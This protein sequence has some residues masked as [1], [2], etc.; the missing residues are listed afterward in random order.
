LAATLL[1]P[2][3]N[4]PVSIGPVTGRGKVVDINAVSAINIP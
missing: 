3:S 4:N 1:L 2:A